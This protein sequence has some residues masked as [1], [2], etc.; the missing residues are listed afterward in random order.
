MCRL[1]VSALIGPGD[2][3]GPEPMTEGRSPRDY[4]PL[5]HFIAVHVWETALLETELLIHAAKVAKSS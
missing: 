1:Y 4:D 5:H 2:R 3:K